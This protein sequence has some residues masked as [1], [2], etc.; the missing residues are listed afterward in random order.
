MPNTISHKKHNKECPIGKERATWAFFRGKNPLPDAPLLT[1]FLPA[2]P[3]LCSAKQARCLFSQWQR[4]H[5]NLEFTFQDYINPILNSEAFSPSRLRAF[6]WEI[7]NH[8]HKMLFQTHSW[9]GDH[10]RTIPWLPC[11]PWKK[12][13]PRRISAQAVSSNTSASSTAAKQARF[14]FSQWQ[15]LHH[16][17]EFTF[18]DY[19]NPIL[20]PESFSP[21]A[22][23]LSPPF[24]SSCT[25]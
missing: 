8:Q 3:H 19:I 10:P 4:P 18:Q 25:S 14:L 5:H 7:R 6:A 1:P 17:L 21:R 22:F 23:T 12:S 16:N 15:R 9:Q 11:R 24:S 20:N 13:P 2:R